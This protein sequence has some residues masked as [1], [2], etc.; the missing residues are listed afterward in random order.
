MSSK[1]ILAAIA[2]TLTNKAWLNDYCNIFTLSISY[3]HTLSIP[4][5]V[6]DE[7]CHLGKGNRQA[8]T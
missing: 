1:L 2:E 5:S 7:A 6:L 4:S 8:I 3:T